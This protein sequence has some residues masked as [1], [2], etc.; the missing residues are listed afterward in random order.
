MAPM[1]VETS[2]ALPVIGWGST[3]SSGPSTA[4]LKSTTE[5]CASGTTPCTAATIAVASAFACSMVGP[6]V[7][8][9][10][11]AISMSAFAGRAGT[12]T[13]AALVP[14]LPA[15]TVTS[16]VGGVT[17]APAG[18]ASTTVIASAAAAA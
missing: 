16:A 11:I 8:V 18:I 7:P 3:Y 1:A 12:C 17:V 2:A 6:I 14:E 13:V 15:A 5:N 10:S 4:S 9:V